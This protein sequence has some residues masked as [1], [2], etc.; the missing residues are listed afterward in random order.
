MRKALESALRQ[1]LWEMDLPQDAPLRLVREK[2]GIAVC[3]VQLPERACIL[4]YF[5]DPADRREITAYQFLGFAGIP[6]I[7]LLLYTKKALLL[8]DL[9]GH[10]QLRPARTAD[11]LD[12]ERIRFLAKWYKALHRAGRSAGD[13][14]GFGRET[15][16]LTLEGLRLLRERF[17]DYPGASLLERR[18]PRLRERLASLGETLLY[19]DFALENL[20]AG[21]AQK[22]LFPYDYNCM[23]WGYPFADV[24][25]VCRSLSA[26]MGAVFRQSYGASSPAE[27]QAD[28]VA[29]PLIALIHACAL[30]DFPE[31]AASSRDALL[32]GAVARDADQWLG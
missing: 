14:P 22:F 20:A 5:A 16:A 26:E 10:E 15:D 25:N 19:N 4:K 12:P 3:R 8:A 6:T 24:R 27:V 2:N 17:G 23:G 11:L 32:S 18:L 31:W 29:A 9:R 1:E 21:R 13:L 7:P 30:P 28:A